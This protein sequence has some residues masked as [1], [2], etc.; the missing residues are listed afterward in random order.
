MTI[1]KRRFCTR[2]GSILPPNSRY[3]PKCG[4]PV[5]AGP[6]KTAVPRATLFNSVKEAF[7]TLV[8]PTPPITRPTEVVYKK[9]PPYGSIRKYLFLGIVLFFVGLLLNTFGIFLLVPLWFIIAVCLAPLVYA[10]WMYRQDRLE[11]EPL[12]LI[13]SS[14]GWGAFS[15]F[16]V[17]LLWLTL[18]VVAGVDVNA[19]PAW[20]GGPLPEEPL[21]ILGVY[22]LATHKSLG[23]E[24]NDHLDGMVYGAAAGAGFA[25]A[26]NFGYIF[27]MVT[28]GVPLPWAVLARSTIGHVFFSG[29]VGR[30]LGLAKIRKGRIKVVD[31]IP[32]LAVAMVLHGLWNFLV[33][34]PLLDPFWL[35]FYYIGG[36]YGVIIAVF[37]IASPYYLIMY[38]YAKEALRDEKLWGYSVGYAPVEY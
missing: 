16:L 26:E 2:C 27:S 15:A 37:L 10:L 19:I 30:C 18:Y 12:E 7:V 31:L 6:P 4:S 25:I 34:T 32:G 38:K 5:K 29:L 22:W 28:E 14:L 20:I 24:F 35:F 9:L 33:T 36:D 1:Q 21:K 17:I 8:K 11:A 13:V 23:K 3:C